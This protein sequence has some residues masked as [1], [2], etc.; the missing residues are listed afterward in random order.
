[1]PLVE[2]KPDSLARTYAQSFYELAQDKG[3]ESLIQ[4]VLAELEGILELARGDARFNEFLA[5][6]VLATSDRAR[7]IEQV[8]RGKASDLTV[9]F[10]LVLNKKG[11][12]SHLPA[13]VAA[14]DETVQ[15]AFGKIEVDI[16]T[17]SPMSG[18]QLSGI[19]DRLREVLGRDPV[20][21]PYVDASM[22]GGVKMQIGDRLID[23][24][25]STRL[26]QLKARMAT[27]GTNQIRAAAQRLLED[28]E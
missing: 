28:S 5:S 19:K 25:I 18:E 14:L 1:M 27:N 17:A 3:G 2:T 15:E 9:N 10:L 7:S 13:I 23:A 11:R 21:H 16:Y 6:R 8:F 12:L 20:V 4:E 26:Q 24:S 22:I